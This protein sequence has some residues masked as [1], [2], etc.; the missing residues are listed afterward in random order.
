MSGRR[1][2][3]TLRL[4]LFAVALAAGGPALSGTTTQYQ[5]DAL[6]RL[7]K[8]IG[9]YVTTTY[10]YDATGNRTAVAAVQTAY[11]IVVVPGGGIKL[12]YPK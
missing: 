5:Y 9:P 2:T 12:L 1:S 3:T 7:V 10:V 11:K 4:L 8:V 6:G